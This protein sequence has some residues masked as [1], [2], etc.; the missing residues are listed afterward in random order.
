MNRGFRLGRFARQ[1]VNA[2]KFS[3]TS[4]RSILRP[5]VSQLSTLSTARIVP[6]LNLSNITAVLPVE[7]EEGDEEEEPR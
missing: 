3:G 5:I 1:V 2:G 4:S 7:E 6:L